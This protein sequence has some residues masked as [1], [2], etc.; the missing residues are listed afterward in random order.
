ME[1]TY[2]IKTIEELV[3][4]AKDSGNKEALLKDLSLWLEAVITFPLPVIHTNQ[5]TWVD[6]DVTGC[7]Q[8]NV[9]VNS[10]EQ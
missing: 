2:H 5:F 10:C 4:A 9:T 7:S 8:V 1:K 3:Q 6:D